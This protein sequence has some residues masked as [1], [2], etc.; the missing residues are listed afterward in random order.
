MLLVNDLSILPEYAEFSIHLSSGVY[1][2]LEFPA[3]AKIEEQP[4]GL[5]W[6]RIEASNL[7]VANLYQV[8]VKKG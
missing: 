2:S 6:G 7:D 3:V 8:W 4:I 5:A 1:S